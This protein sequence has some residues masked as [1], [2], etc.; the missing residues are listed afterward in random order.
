MTFDDREQAGQA[1]ALRL[2]FLR[3]R[4][5]LVLGLPRGGVVVAAAIARALRAPLDVLL[6]RK[7]GLP[8][9]PE[10]ALAAIGENGVLVGNPGVIRYVQPDPVVLRGVIDRERAVLAQRAA[11]YRSVREQVP[12]AGR[13]VLVADDGIATGATMR[14]AIRVLEVR[15]AAHIVV[16]VPVA[17]PD[18]LR[19]LSGTVDRVVCLR[20]PRRLR[21]V[22]RWYGEF[23]EVADD[24][25]VALLR[26]ATQPLSTVEGT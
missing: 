4:N 9:A 7:I 16:A 11:L 6:V 20:A 23:H 10:L 8:D 5:P 24:E 3:A 25:V 13:S 22:S 12:V 19:A 26:A 14:A 18:A 21:A 15:G 1:L 17:A 2:E